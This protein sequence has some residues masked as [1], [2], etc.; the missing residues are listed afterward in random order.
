LRHRQ[1]PLYDRGVRRLAHGR[2][3]EER[4]DRREARVARP[5]GVAALLLQVVEEFADER[6]IDV[7]DEQVGG[8][9]AEARRGEGQEKPERVAIGG[10][11]V[12]ARLALATE[13]L[14]EERFQQWGKAG[15]GSTPSARS[16]RSPA[17]VS[18]SGEDD[19]Y[20]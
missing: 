20:Q 15:H 13:P 11:R 12:L 6:R 7:G 3:A 1:Y 4:A 2:E 16:R 9:L 14:G 17:D 8:R 19:R 18:R 10:D 5:R